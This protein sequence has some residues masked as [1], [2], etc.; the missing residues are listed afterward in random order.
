[1][2]NRSL[3]PIKKVEDIYELPKYIFPPEVSNCRDP[4]TRELFLEVGINL[5]VYRF[6]IDKPVVIERRVW[7]M[8]NNVGIIA[9]ARTLQGDKVVKNFDPIRNGA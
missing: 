9:K 4:S 6:P 2:R 8:L 5:E 7:H 3:K 1:M